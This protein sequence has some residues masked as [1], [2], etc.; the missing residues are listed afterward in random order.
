MVG[1]SRP[2]RA[3]RYSDRGG[4]LRA[5]RDRGRIADR[6]DD[7]RH[8]TGAASCRGSGPCGAVGALRV[9]YASEGRRLPSQRSADPDG[10][11]HG[12]D[13]GAVC[14]GH[15]LRYSDLL[16]PGYAGD[17]GA[18][19]VVARHRCRVCAMNTCI[20]NFTGEGGTIVQCVDGTYSHA[21]GI[22]GACSRHGGE[23]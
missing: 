22:S 4:D 17:R 9:G 3:D 20:G 5:H 18:R 23:Q 8:L 2:H 11:R 6:Q 13:A 1:K 16:S 7:D 15:Y 10:H 21:G 14:A 12:Y 19:L